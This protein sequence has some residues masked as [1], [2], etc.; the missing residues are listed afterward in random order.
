MN[1]VEAHKTV[2]VA[3]YAEKKVSAKRKP[4]EK[5]VETDESKVAIE[6]E[7]I[8]PATTCV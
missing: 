4:K 5:V 3:K 1:Q 2:H 6:S 7:F 8:I